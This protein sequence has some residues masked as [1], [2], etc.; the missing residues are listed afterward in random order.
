MS[1]AYSH[2]VTAKTSTAAPNECAGD[3]R[4]IKARRR[5]SGGEGSGGIATSSSWTD[6][7]PVMFGSRYRKPRRFGPSDP[8]QNVRPPS[9][10]KT[11]KQLPAQHPFCAN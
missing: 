8:G 11:P 9:S 6:A 4:L 7:H 2:S 1:N 10:V 5:K 3:S